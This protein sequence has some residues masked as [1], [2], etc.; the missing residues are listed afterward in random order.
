MKDFYYANVA[1]NNGEGWTSHAYEYENEMY[2]DLEVL[3]YTEVNTAIE[4]I[5][6]YLVHNNHVTKIDEVHP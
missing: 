4:E 1:F 6:Y 3:G 5:D 2:A